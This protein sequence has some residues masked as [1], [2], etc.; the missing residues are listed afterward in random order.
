MAGGRGTI[1]ME[2]GSGQRSVPSA[3]SFGMTPEGLG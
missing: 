2:G 3:S 1:V